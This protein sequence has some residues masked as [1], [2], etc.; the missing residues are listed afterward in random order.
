MKKNEVPGVQSEGEEE[1]P[2]GGEEPHSQ[3]WM[4]ISGGRE[5]GFCSVVNRMWIYAEGWFSSLVAELFQHLTAVSVE[6]EAKLPRVNEVR[7]QCK[8]SWG[9]DAALAEKT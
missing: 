5:K 4:L 3:R 7:H 2:V 1:G 9:S 6:A 8:L